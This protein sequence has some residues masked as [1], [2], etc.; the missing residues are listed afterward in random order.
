MPGP[1]ILFVSVSWKRN[2]VL[3]GPV[4]PAPVTELPVIVSCSVTQAR[5]PMAGLNCWKEKLSVL[6]VVGV[7]VIDWSIAVAGSPPVHVHCAF[8][9]EK[10]KKVRPTE[11]NN[12]FK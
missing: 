1:V 4:L 8:S 10:E 12:P 11:T 5:F 7:I 3:S 6:V 9:N 2:A